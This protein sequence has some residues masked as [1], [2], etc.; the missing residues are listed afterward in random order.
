M[1]GSVAPTTSG[2]VPPAL[3][4]ALLVDE[5]GLAR[6]RDRLTGAL[7]GRGLAAGDRVVVLCG[8]RPEML[9]ARESACALDLVVVPLDP[10]L[11][12]PE[13]AYV[14]AHARPRL[15]L[16]E[17]GVEPV[18]EAALARLLPIRRP[19]L[20]SLEAIAPLPVDAAARAGRPAAGGGS[21]GAP[22]GP[23]MI[24]ATLLYTSGTTGRPKGCMRSAAQEAARAAELVTT[25][26][27]GSDDVHLVAC[28]LAYSAPGIFARAARSVG[29]RTVLLPRFAAGELLATAAAARVTFC[30]LVPTQLQRLLALPEPARRAADL[31]SLRA[32]VI[33]GAPLAPAVRRAA[34]EW[35][36]EGRVWEFYGSSETG[37]I[38]ILR[39]EEQ[40]E[41]ADSVGRAAP[42]VAL[43]LRPAR[44]PD[45]RHGAPHRGRQ[46]EAAGEPDGGAPRAGEIFVRSPSV[47]SGYWNPVTGLVDWPGDERGF[48]SVGDLGALDAGGYLHLVGRLHDTIISGGVNVYPAEVER[49]LVEHEQV[50]SAVVC[51]LADPDW[52][53][54][55]AAAVV[56][57]P[58]AR[59]SAEELREALRGRLAPHKLPRRIVFVEADALPRTSSGKPIRRAAAALLRR[60]APGG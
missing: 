33:A 54:L 44:D 3:L 34:V 2:S 20:L 47:M 51:G 41:H 50:E 31:S 18:A 11:A 49:A 60:M 4:P 42:G 22:G 8:T 28:P 21:P 17:P 27:L 46:G 26:A 39:P 37:T 59:I 53:Q 23:G 5:E 15:V 32:L 9:A 7:R 55:V 10:R 56:P 1:L 45:E 35:L 38:T 52:G 13:V 19:A 25:Y 24:G 58:G 12:P 16:V 48:L 57:A 40:L 6:A 14:L 30:F 43:E 29:A 36:G